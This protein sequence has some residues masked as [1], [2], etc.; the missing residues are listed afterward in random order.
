MSN[1]NAIVP[2][3]NSTLKELQELV[4]LTQFLADGMSFYHTVAGILIQGGIVGPVAGNSLSAALPFNAGFPKQV[5]GVFLQP[6]GT[7]VAGAGARYS[8]GANV[9]DLNNFQIANDSASAMS[10]YWWAIGL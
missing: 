10:F 3:E 1:N 5:F 2:F 7:V 8:A 6:I 9:I 4:G